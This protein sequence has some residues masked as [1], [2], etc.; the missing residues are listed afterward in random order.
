MSLND[1]HFDPVLRAWNCQRKLTSRGA[2]L[3]GSP[4]PFDQRK[5]I[6]IELAPVPR[7]KSGNGNGR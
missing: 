6:Q 2:V 3:Y 4:H 5:A 1:S 7:A